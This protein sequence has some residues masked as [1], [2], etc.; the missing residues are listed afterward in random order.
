[1]YL[2]LVDEMDKSY[3]KQALVFVQLLK[4]NVKK[5]YQIKLNY[6]TIRQL[7]A[8]FS[9]PWVLTSSSNNLRTS[10][11]L[12]SS[13][14]SSLTISSFL[15]LR[16]PLPLFVADKVIQ[17]FTAFSTFSEK[18]LSKASVRKLNNAKAVTIKTTRKINLGSNQEGK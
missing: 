14:S 15:S 17:L 11:S 9:F 18:T 2:V 16:H 4:P 10:K 8:S 12:L 3:I 1:M 6:L 5:R 7:I 13:S